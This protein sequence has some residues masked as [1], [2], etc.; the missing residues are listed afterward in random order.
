DDAYRDLRYSGEDIPTLKSMDTYGIVLYCGSF[1]K[2]VSP[3]LRVG[4]LV[5]NKDFMDKLAAAKQVSDVHTPV[6]NQIIIHKIMKEHDF[7]GHIAKICDIYRNKLQITLDCL[8]KHMG[9][10][11]S[12][13]KPEGGLYVFCKLPDNVDAMEFFNEGIKA[14]VAVVYGSAFY[15]D[16]NAKSPYFRINFSA[17]S[18]EQLKEGIAI[19]G[20][21]LKK[22]L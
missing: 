6:L 1:S 7:E 17:A 14:G 3:G 19:L 15:V 21:V 20:E 9:D 18:E 5:A 4:Y 12:Y 2:V 8:D 10:N 11:I 22:L 13:V 16:P